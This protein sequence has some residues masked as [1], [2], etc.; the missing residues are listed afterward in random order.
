MPRI[1]HVIC[2]RLLDIFA[3]LFVTIASHGPNTC[4]IFSCINFRN[5]SLVSDSVMGSAI[6][7]WVNPQIATIILENP[8]NSRPVVLSTS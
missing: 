5:S 4:S 3:S 8:A 7:K 1:P 6:I 2:T